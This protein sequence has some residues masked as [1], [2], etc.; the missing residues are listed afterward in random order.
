MN[1]DAMK[2]LGQEKKRRSA[3]PYWIWESVQM[4][5]DLLDSCFDAGVEEQINHVLDQFQKRKINHIYLLG[6]GSSYFLTLALRYLFCE[7]TDI[8]VSC[9]VTNVFESYPPRNLDQHSAV[10]IHST[11]G[12]SEGDKQVVEFAQKFGAYVIGVTDIPDSTL[13]EAVD[14]VIIGPGGA[15]VELPAT[16]TFATALMRMTMFI[17]ALA[18]R[19]GHDEQAQ[20]YQ[21]ALVLLPDMLREIMIEI[22]KNADSYVDV[23]KTCSAFQVIGFGPNLA[24]ADE[25]ALALS[26]CG[27]IPAM[28]FE[29][30]NFIHGPLQ[31]LTKNMGVVAF[32]PAGQLQD[33]MLRTVMAAKTIGAKTIILAPDNCENIPY[34]DILIRLPKNIPDLLSPIVYMVPMWQIAYRLAL[35]GNGGHPDRL[36]MDKP[37]FIKA[38]EYLMNKDKWVA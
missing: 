7:T 18:K 35:L 21:K 20:E 23:L 10:F 5:P 11:S 4:I 2:V 28:S 24:T 27:G 32:A 29:M 36:A 30:E 1:E 13:A 26:Q 16:R 12:K 17:L 31:T 14:D 8:P 34:A 38:F 3:H 25:T 19:Q 9:V 15:K 37:E 6:R 33:R 22:E